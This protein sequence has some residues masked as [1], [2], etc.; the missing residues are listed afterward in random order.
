MTRLP[1]LPRKAPP[2]TVQTRD[3]STFLALILVLAIAGGLVGLTA[4]VL[5]GMV[6]IVGLI[7]GAGLFFVLH[8]VTWGR[9]L[10]R[11][12]TNEGYQEEPVPVPPLMQSLP[13]D[14][15]DDGTD[16]PR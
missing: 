6:S 10:M 16:G 11:I 5:P 9:A 2:V 1:R 15:E 13:A 7:A 12:R 3:S 4:L 14:F 8:Y